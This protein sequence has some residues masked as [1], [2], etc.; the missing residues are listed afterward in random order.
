MGVALSLSPLAFYGQTEIQRDVIASAGR[1]AIPFEDTTSGDFYE[2]PFTIGEVNVSLHAG[3]GEQGE[4]DFTEGFQ[5][6]DI[7]LIPALE[8][9]TASTIAQCPQY[10]DGSVV[11]NYGGCVGPFN[12]TLVGNG[13]TLF[14]DDLPE[15]DMY[16]FENLDSGYYQVTVRGSNFCAHRDTPREVKNN[17]CDVQ[18]YTGITPN[19]DGKN[20]QWIV[21]NLEINPINSVI[22]YNR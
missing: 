7:V 5:Q 16:V 14:V 2:V 10:Y 15:D 9:F 12:I 13:D 3:F 18:I 17:T 1:I 11:V 8:V 4:F 19:G 22:I 6:G 20:D 21:D